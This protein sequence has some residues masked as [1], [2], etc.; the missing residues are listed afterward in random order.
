MVFSGL[1]PR[2]VEI[3][4]WGGQVRAAA[5]A[6]WHPSC[7]YDLHH[8]SRQP[9]T[10]N[11]LI[12]AKDQTRVLMDTSRVCYPCKPWWELR[13]ILLLRGQPLSSHADNYLQ[14]AIDH[15]RSVLTCV[16]FFPFGLEIQMSHREQC[17][18]HLPLRKAFWLSW[19]L[20]YLAAVCEITGR[21]EPLGTNSP[22]LVILDEPRLLG[23]L[24]CHPL[25]YFWLQEGSQREWIIISCAGAGA[26]CGIVNR[27]GN[28]Y[29]C[30]AALFWIVLYKLN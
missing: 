7:V 25:T 21:A 15:C 29:N 20:T 8:S 16:Q 5:T 17:V 4:R 19:S 2:H 23:T 30:P 1:H 28:I 13:L 9:W 12:E 18:T 10:L 26:E 27:C 22:C 14:A 6:M 3:P 11:P 24:W